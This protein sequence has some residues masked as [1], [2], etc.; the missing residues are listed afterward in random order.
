MV[1]ENDF[2]RPWNSRVSRL[3]CSGACDCYAA[4][5]RL[6]PGKCVEIGL[7]SMD[8]KGDTGL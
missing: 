8:D 3:K 5:P 4:A 2:K 7:G 1:T 6:L